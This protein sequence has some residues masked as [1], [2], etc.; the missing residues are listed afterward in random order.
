M[1]KVAMKVDSTSGFLQDIFMFIS[2]FLLFLELKTH[3]SDLSVKDFFVMQQ[4]L[5]W[6]C[7][8]SK[9]APIWKFWACT[10]QNHHN[11]TWTLQKTQ[12]L[13]ISY[14]WITILLQNSFVFHDI[15]IL[16]V[17]KL[18]W[19]TKLTLA[20]CS[21]SLGSCCTS[22]CTDKNVQKLHK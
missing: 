5:V 15:F 7:V 11:S 21:R 4:M 1:S 17:S 6:T 19:F 2:F 16:L 14:Q 12:R 9:G 10:D 20:Q 13:N 3:C 8:I 22:M 18:A